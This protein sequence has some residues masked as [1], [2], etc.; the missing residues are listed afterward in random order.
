MIRIGLETTVAEIRI[1]SAGEYYL[2]EKKPE[3]QRRLVKGEILLQVEREGGLKQSSVFR[4]QVASFSRDELASDLKRKLSKLLDEPVIVYDNKANGLKQVR[5]GECLTRSD[6]QDLQKKLS[7]SG[8]SDAF[9]VSD[10]APKAGGRTS[11]SLRGPDNLFLLSETGFLF[12]PSS[13]ENFL[14]CNGKPYR[15]LFDIFPNK[16]GRLTVVNQLAMEEYLLGVLPAEIN[17]KSYPEPAALAAIAIAARTYAMKNTGRFRADGF[18]LSD[19]TRSQVY[20]GV[21]LENKDTDEAVQQTAGLAVYY[22]GKLIDAMYMSTC[23]GRTEDSS[24]V[25][26]TPPVP[27]LKSVFAQLKALPARERESWKGGTRS[28]R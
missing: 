18:D 1:S 21:S 13:P 4:V 11:L 28:N 24:N 23:G 9:I 14:R 16:G 25:F 2:T 6:A 12:Q 17:P 22:D 7:A 10:S 27:Y 5:V 15:G 3:A 8:Y 19:D 26:D 20:E